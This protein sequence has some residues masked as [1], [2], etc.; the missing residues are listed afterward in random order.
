M[1]KVFMFLVGV[2]AFNCA[3]AQKTNVPAVTMVSFEQSWL[4]RQATVA[5]KNHTNEEV[6]SIEFRIYYYD[7][8]SGAQIDYKD[9]AMSVSIAP[10]LT[11]K[12]QIDAYDREHYANYYLSEASSSNENLSFDVKFELLGYNM[13]FPFVLKQYFADT[14]TLIISL[15]WLAL[16]IGLWLFLLAIVGRMARDRN[17]NATLWMLLSILL[18]PI[19]IIVVLMIIGDDKKKME[20]ETGPGTRMGLGTGP[21]PRMGMGPRSRMGQGPRPWDDDN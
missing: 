3:L 9:F 7:K 18:T 6:K 1:K 10:R 5:L 20:T 16:I 2:L 15:F 12:I 4:D 14:D 8:K 19:P 11:K 13:G 17:R 21:G